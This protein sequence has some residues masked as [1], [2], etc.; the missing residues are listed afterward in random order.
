MPLNPLY[1]KLLLILAVMG[2]ML[3][4]LFTE[5]GHRHTDLLLLKLTGD[6]ELNLDL[7]KLSPR[8]NEA[9]FRSQFPDLDLH[10]Q[11]RPGPF[12]NRTCVAEIRAFNGV[13]ARYASLFL[14]GNDIRAVKI[15]YRRPYHQSLLEQLRH[16]L[17]AA[18]ETSD[19]TA[20]TADDS[21]V[22]TWSTAEGLVVVSRDRV[23]L[24]DEPAL[25]WLSEQTAREAPSRMGTP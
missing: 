3:W 19:G 22:L 16:N 20:A 23:D 24:R 17:G 15:S 11:D 7:H 10:C 1:K 12:G 14:D 21:E 18:Q 13:P 2:P 9:E 5:D 6:P 8:V 25:F 4:L